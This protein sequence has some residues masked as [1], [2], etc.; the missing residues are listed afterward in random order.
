MHLARAVIA[1][2]GLGNGLAGLALLFA[3]QWFFQNIAPFD[4]YNR[5][6]LGDI[7][8]F[9]LPI[10]AGLIYAAYQPQRYWPLLVLGLWANAIHALNHLYDNLW[11]D[12]SLEHFLR[13]GLPL[14][15]AAV[16]L[17]WAWWALRKGA[18]V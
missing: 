17:V 14:S 1:L 12:R 10:G 11:L 9:N 5:H 4:P 15:V 7:G 6:F 3:P 13:D 8:A 16:A 18:T 2:V